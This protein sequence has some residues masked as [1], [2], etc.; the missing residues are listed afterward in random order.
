MYAIGVELSQ[1]AHRTQWR[2]LARQ[3][4]I[5]Q[6]QAGTD[7][8]LPMRGA[9][10]E[11]IARSVGVGGSTGIPDQRRFVEGDL[12]R[13]LSESRVPGAERKLTGKEEACWVATA[14]ASPPKGRARWTLQAAGRC[15]SQAHRP[16]QP[17]DESVRR[18]L[19]E[20]T[21]NPGAKT[22]GGIPQSMANTSPAWRTC[23]ISMRGVRPK[24][25]VV[26]FDRKSRATHRRGPSANPGHAGPA[27][28]YD[29]EYR[30]QWGRSSLRFSS[31]CIVPGARSSL[32]ERRAAKDYA[33]CMVTS[34]TSIIR[35]RDH[36]G[37]AG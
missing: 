8:W 15:D 6:A 13:A 5:P 11:E 2:C 30:R 1:R 33:K 35:C 29:Y 12:E 26:C 21:S 14:C 25:P 18:R 34:S 3:A 16:Q 27:E 36:P 7:L 24:R 20:M 28:R 19:A 37:C 31:T 17:V 10:T 23:L 22:C 9:A 32:T 4:C